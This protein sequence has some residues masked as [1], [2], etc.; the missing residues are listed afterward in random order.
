[1]LTTVWG[2]DDEDSVEMFEAIKAAG[3]DVNYVDNQNRSLLYLAAE[4]NDLALFDFV[5]VQNPLSVLTS[6]HNDKFQQ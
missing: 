4:K 1:M 5:V 6:N 3:F 2:N